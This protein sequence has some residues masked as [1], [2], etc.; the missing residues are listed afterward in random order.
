MLTRPAAV[1]LPYSIAIVELAEQAGL[2]IIANIVGRSVEDV[3]IG[4]AV[5]VAFEQHDDAFV[6]VFEPA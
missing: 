3:S 1:R 4:M 6:P 2:R 5:C